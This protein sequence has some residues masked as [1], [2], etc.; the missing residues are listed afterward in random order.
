[1]GITSTGLSSG[2]NF[3]Q[4]IQ[5]VQDSQRR[6][7]VLLQSRQATYQKE[8]T[9]VQSVS[10]KLSTLLAVASSVNNPANFNTNTVSVGKTTTGI[11]LLS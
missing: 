8:I 4:L 1:M 5:Q 2:I 6:P 9:A 10:I 3:D 7:V 11:S